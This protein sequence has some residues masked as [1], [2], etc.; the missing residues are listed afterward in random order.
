MTSPA[1]R[2][3]SRDG[4]SSAAPQVD[5]AVA[6]LSLSDDLQKVHAA[7][8]ALAKPG[9]TSKAAQQPAFKVAL[10]RLVEVA[11]TGSDEKDR[12][13]GNPTYGPRKPAVR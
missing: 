13:R 6:L 3:T 10:E 9:A 4:R 11:Q 1:N 5:D 2:R 12:G 7:A 8:V